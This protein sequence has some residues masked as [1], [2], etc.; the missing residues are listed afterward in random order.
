M[1]SSRPVPKFDIEKNYK[2]NLLMDMISQRRMLRQKATEKPHEKVVLLVQANKQIQ[3]LVQE[4]S[5]LIQHIVHGQEILYKDEFADVDDA[6]HTALIMDIKIGVKGV[7]TVDKKQKLEDLEKQIVDEEQFLQR[8]R[9]M[10]TNDD[11]TKKA[12][13]EVIEEKK[14]KM[15]EVKQRITQLQVEIQKLKMLKK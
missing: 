7:R 8:T 1:N 2:M 10:L 3:E 6:F 4:H 14:Q 15:Q 11:F 9:M 5:T 12:P 13:P